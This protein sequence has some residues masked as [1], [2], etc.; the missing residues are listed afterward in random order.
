M[1]PGRII[2]GMARTFLRPRFLLAQGLGNA[3]TLQA[4][5]TKFA[6]IKTQDEII[7]H[8]L[9]ISWSLGAKAG[10]VGVVSAVVAVGISGD[11]LSIS[12]GTAGIGQTSGVGNNGILFATSLPALAGSVNDL[13]LS[14]NSTIHLRQ[15]DFTSGTSWGIFLSG[16][17]GNVFF[18][19][20]SICLVYNS[21]S[22]LGN[23]G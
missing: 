16:N 9:E 22:E 13:V 17:P 5:L 19:N 3:A 20:V 23:R 14:G 18:A 21:I 12:T 2:D 8:Q 11:A 10:A 1:G 4:G 15:G 6:E 7:G